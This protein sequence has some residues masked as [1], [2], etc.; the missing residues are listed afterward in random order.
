VALHPREMSQTGFYAK[1]LLLGSKYNPEGLL[2]WLWI[3]GEEE[4]I[5]TTLDRWKH[6]GYPVTQKDLEHCSCDPNFQ[7]FLKRMLNL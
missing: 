6:D 2:Y 3:T 7:T 1:Q 4:A 5:R